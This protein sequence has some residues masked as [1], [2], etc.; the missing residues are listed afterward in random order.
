M[1]K[2]IFNEFKIEIPFINTMQFNS[3]WSRA[4]RDKIRTI[5]VGW[6]EGSSEDEGPS[7]F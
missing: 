4:K 6:G 7:K 2:F 1:S 3:G 5:I